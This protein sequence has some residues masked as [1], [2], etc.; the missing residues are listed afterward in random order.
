[1]WWAW[2]MDTNLGI[3]K[4]L[5][6]RS[7]DATP[8]REKV[9]LLELR[10]FVLACDCWQYFCTSSLSLFLGMC[11][12]APAGPLIAYLSTIY[13]NL[14]SGTFGDS[15]RKWSDNW[16]KKHPEKAEKLQNHHPLH[17]MNEANPF[18]GAEIED[19]RGQGFEVRNLKAREFIHFSDFVLVGLLYLPLSSWQQNSPR[20]H[21]IDSGVSNNLP[22]CESKR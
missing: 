22:T 3:R 4:S 2:R 20:I 7:F 13:R 19:G 6:Q 18:F 1:M 11:T 9:S 8:A 21:L 16:V 10:A 5:R 15:I 14:P 17:A 12:S